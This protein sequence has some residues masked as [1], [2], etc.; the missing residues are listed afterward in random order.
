MF[1]NKK[2]TSVFIL[3]VFLL[4]IFSCQKKNPFAEY[5]EWILGEWVF[6]DDSLE[7]QTE[8]FN[9]I[10]KDSCVVR[11]GYMELFSNKYYGNKTAY[12]L[13]NDTLSLFDLEEVCWKKVKIRFQTLDTMVV[14]WNPGL[15]SIRT[16]YVKT[17]YPVNDRY[18]FDQVIVVAVYSRFIKIV[19]IDK[20]GKL[21]Y[22]GAV[23]NRFEGL[24]TSMEGKENFKQ[25]ELLFNAANHQNKYADFSSMKTEKESTAGT[26]IT[27]VKNNKLLTIAGPFY[28]ED[29]S[30]EKTTNYSKELDWAFKQTA[31]LE[32][33]I[34]IESI[35]NSAYK[36]SPAIRTVND[37]PFFRFENEDKKRL[38]LTY[39]E[40]FYLWTKILDA[41]VAYNEFKPCY[42]VYY[43]DNKYIQS[44]GRY[45]RY[46]TDKG[47]TV[48]LDLGFNFIEE[49]Q[50]GDKFQARR[51]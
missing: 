38:H 16:S 30:L 5:P 29:E 12:Q 27:F 13:R 51:K 39:S 20:S 41:K 18:L 50:L 35:N 2:N 36:N 14:T 44:D 1:K 48:T 24:Y 10:S 34:P 26:P 49:N 40:I 45:F 8:G 37:L 19:S 46:Q 28:A 33:Q 47:E 23:G 17:K 7:L 6:V 32:Q 21:F 9:F 22:F 4:L 25:I 43:N 42:K 3:F 15:S 31:F 11:P